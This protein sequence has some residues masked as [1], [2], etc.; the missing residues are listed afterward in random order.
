MSRR[1]KLIMVFLALVTAL[2]VQAQ[3]VTVTGKV[4]DEAGLPVPGASVFVPGTTRGV[5]TDDKGNFAFELPASAKEIK[6]SCIGYDDVDLDLS[7][8]KLKDLSIV[9]KESNTFLESAVAVGYGSPKKVESLVG[10]VTTVNSESIRTAP[11]SSALD[12]LQGQVAGL[13]VL[14]SGGVA[15]DN[16]VSMKLH[17]TGS[18]TSSSSPLY[19]IDGVP[20]SSRSIMALN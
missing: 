15:G 6:I 10:S 8:S 12:A 4:Q 19:I 11:S 14:T 1:I 13:A 5:I 7:Q 3:N 18:L 17:G 2:S 16:S 20:A 9:L